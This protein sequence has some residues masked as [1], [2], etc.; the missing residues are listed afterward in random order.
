MRLGRGGF[1]LPLAVVAVIAM[2]IIAVGAYGL[3][4]AQVRAILWESRT[5]QAQAIAE[6]GLEDA[7]NNVARNASWKAGYPS[8]KYFA[9]GYYTVRVSTDPAPTITSTGYARSIPGLGRASRTVQAQAKLDGFYDFANSTFT[10]NWYAVAYNSNVN[11]KPTCNIVEMQSLSSTSAPSKGCIYGLYVLGNDKVFIASSAVNPIHWS[12]D[13]AYA[14][15]TSTAPFADAV[16]GKVV[17]AASRVTVPNWEEDPDNPGLYLTQNDNN[18]TRIS[19]FSAYNATTGILSVTSGDVELSSGTFYFKGIVVASSRTLFIQLD[20]TDQAANIYLEG[21]LSVAYQGRIDTTRGTNNKDDCGIGTN[22]DNGGCKACNVHIYGRGG[23]TM[24][25]EGY[26][27]T[28]TNKLGTGGGNGAC[29]GENFTYLDIYAPEDEI[30]IKQRF[31]GRVVGKKVDII[32][33]YP[34]DSNNTR[35]YPVYFFD[36]KCGYAASQGVRWV[37]GTWNASYKK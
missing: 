8:P 12:G 3:A 1:T 22:E 35:N 11:D 15:P 9:G 17:L 20:R 27:V 24:I 10:M 33:P 16:K 23:G 25:L 30:V 14:E 37:S 34:I 7:L 32:S 31:L 18:A 36:T 4:R 5:L 28:C 6:A 29:K 26:D 13:A 19:P 21:N 2:G